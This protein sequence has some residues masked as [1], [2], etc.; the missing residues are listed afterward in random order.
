MNQAVQSKLDRGRKAALT[1]ARKSAPVLLKCLRVTMTVL[2]LVNFVGNDDAA[3]PALAMLAAV[4]HMVK[5]L[6]GLAN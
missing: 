2:W 4:I 1:I 5:I 6:I 3:S